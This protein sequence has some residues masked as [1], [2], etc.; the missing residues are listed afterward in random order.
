MRLSR[1]PT[2]QEWAEI[3]ALGPGVRMYK[4]K[5]TLFYNGEILG[6]GSREWLI[7]NKEERQTWQCIIVLPGV[8]VIPIW[9]FWSCKNVK[10]VIMANSVRRIE[11]A[12]FSRCHGLV[13]VKLS[14]NLEYI[15]RCAFCGCFSLTSIFI[16]PSC[17]EIC[18]K[19]FLCCSKLIIFHVPQHTR[20]GDN[21]FTSQEYALH[22]ACCS[23]NPLFVIIYQIIR[24]NGLQS[25]K[26]PNRMG[27]TPLQY[28]DANPFARVD[29][30][31]IINRYILEMMGETV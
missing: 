8:E 29:Q 22:R 15:G 21:V 28:L 19:A 27:I 26:V 14:W 1:N 13:F 6:N 18:K 5:K 16:P 2:E 4:D 3:V 9:A 20:I 24:R 7:Y 25:F 31:K 23:F 10:T 30:K 12:A 11:H 17:R